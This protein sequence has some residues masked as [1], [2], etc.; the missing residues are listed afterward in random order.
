M[1]KQK[2]VFAVIRFDFWPDRPEMVK[3]MT[4]K[5][6]VPTQ[7]RAESEVERLNKLNSPKGAHYIWQATRLVEG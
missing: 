2:Q 6:I 7:A 3:G 1:K 5:E 4:V